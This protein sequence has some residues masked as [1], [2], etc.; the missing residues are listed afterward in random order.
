MS[1]LGDP[2]EVLEV[3]RRL[4]S[5]LAEVRA[6]ATS[7]LARELDRLRA[8]L[9]EEA[10]TGQRRL[11]EDLEQVLGLVG[12]S[13]RDTTRRLDRMEAELS[14]T[15]R[16]V[17]QLARQLSSARLEVRFGAPESNGNGVYGGG[18]RSPYP[19]GPAAQG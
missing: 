18:H 4:E 19:V 17:E 13:W 3:V 8:D 6:R 5:E 11:V 7:P 1:D 2:Q 9:V 14:A 12:D 10:A 15:A 16:A